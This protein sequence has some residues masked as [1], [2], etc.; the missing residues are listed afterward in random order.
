[1]SWLTVRTGRDESSGKEPLVTSS[2]T[3]SREPLFSCCAF[4]SKTEEEASNPRLD[5][6]VDHHQ[7]KAPVPD[8]TETA[9]QPESC[10]RLRDLL[11]QGDRVDTSNSTNLAALVVND[12]NIPEFQ[13]TQRST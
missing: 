3:R 2:S 9:E 5:A 10:S 13:R 7:A 1:M 11:T 12:E 4:S 6:T 8:E